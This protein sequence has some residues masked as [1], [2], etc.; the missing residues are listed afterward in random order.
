MHGQQN[1][2]KINRNQ[3]T[4]SS[5]GCLGSELCSQ[6]AL[7]LVASKANSS[8]REIKPE[9]LLLS[10]LSRE[11]CMISK[12]EPNAKGRREVA[13]LRDGW[14]V[15][16]AW[17]SHSLGN[18]GSWPPGNMLEQLGRL[19]PRPWGGDVIGQAWKVTKSQPLGRG[20]C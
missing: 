3:P 8:H 4:E 20:W 13:L 6:L 15:Q 18:E 1:P 16:G 12:C 7:L 14:M 9:K 19:H 10:L 2:D 5:F 11:R 17:G